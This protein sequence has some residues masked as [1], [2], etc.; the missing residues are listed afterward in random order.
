MK[1]TL[2]LLSTGFLL[3]CCGAED[4]S[5]ISTDLV[6]PRQIAARL[7]TVTIHLVQVDTLKRPDCTTLL[8]DPTR[9]QSA[10]VV[11]RAVVEFNSSGITQK[12]IDNIP[13]RGT[14]WEFYAEGHDE[15]QAL[16]GHGCAGVFAI[17]K[18]EELPVTIHLCELAENPCPVIP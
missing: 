2:A 6:I 14:V 5:S 15:T 4:L 1:K 10:N 3:A 12:I 7:S 8:G 18:G 9:I 16:I 17:S 11:K 13:D